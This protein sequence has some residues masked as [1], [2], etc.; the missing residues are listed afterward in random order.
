[1]NRISLVCADMAGTTVSD[2][3]IVEQ[4]A[5]VALE[6]CG[7]PAGSSGHDSAMSYIRQTMGQSKIEVFRAVTSDED[8]A[9]LAN[10]SFERN[11]SALATDGRITA[12]PHAV[13]ALKALRDKGIKIAL[14]TG[15]APATQDAI[16]RALDWE[17]L[18]DLA[19][20]PGKELR[21]RPNPDMVLHAV[22]RLGIDDV[23]EVAVVGDSVN[24][25][26]S[27][28]R[29]GASVVAGV[30]TGSHDANALRKAGAT[31]VLDD[32][33]QLPGLVGA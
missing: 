28:L 27:G 8:T 17:T 15:F 2:G 13:D 30:T 33:G 3:G 26:Y 14:T 4:A 21:G 23:R 7:I 12:L 18:I 11:I 19:V 6:E 24:D 10:A 32:I 31:H 22:L 16:L 9:Q 29:A 20:A 25:V 5:S 1:M